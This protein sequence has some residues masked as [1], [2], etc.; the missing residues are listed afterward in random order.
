M[1]DGMQIYGA[2]EKPKSGLALKIVRKIGFLI[3]RYRLFLIGL[4]LGYLIG[5]A[6]IWHTQEDRFRQMQMQLMD[7]QLYD[8]NSRLGPNVP[9]PRR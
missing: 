9:M 1:N 8:I 3:F 2:P 5:R 6:S 4:C 7:R